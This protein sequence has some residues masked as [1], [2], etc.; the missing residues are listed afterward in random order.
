MLFALTGYRRVEA[1]LA[2]LSHGATFYWV[3]HFVQLVGELL[4]GE[5]L[6]FVL[7]VDECFQRLNDFAGRHL[8]NVV[9]RI[10]LVC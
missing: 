8:F 6:R 4:V 1:F 9:V 2:I 7:V 5:G 3:S 10:A